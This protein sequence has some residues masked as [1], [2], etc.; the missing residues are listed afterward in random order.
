[1]RPIIGFKSWMF[2][3]SDIYEVLERL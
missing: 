3:E 2:E 1:M